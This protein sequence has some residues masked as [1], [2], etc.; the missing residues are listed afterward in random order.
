MKCSYPR[1][2]SGLTD[3]TYV[4]EVDGVDKLAPGTYYFTCQVH[5]FMRGTLIAD[6]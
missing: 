6:P 5:P 4:H 2:S 1:F 3:W